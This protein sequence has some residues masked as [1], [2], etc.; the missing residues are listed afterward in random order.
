MHYL[1]CLCVIQT[2][3]VLSLGIG[4]ITLAC[5]VHPL[6]L[7]LAATFFPIL[8]VLRILATTHL[9]KM[10]LSLHVYPEEALKK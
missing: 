9:Q 8:I 10:F 6:F 2:L 7:L 5:L 3:S 4:V 1:I